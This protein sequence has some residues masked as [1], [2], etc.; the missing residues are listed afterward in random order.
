MC[1]V[2]ALSLYDVVLVCSARERSSDIEC[3]FNCVEL[4]SERVQLKCDEELRQKCL[5]YMVCVLYETATTT[6]ARRDCAQSLIPSTLPVDIVGVVVVAAVV[7]ATVFVVVV[8]VAVSMSVMTAAVV[9][10]RR[11]H[12]SVRRNEINEKNQS[13]RRDTCRNSD[14][15]LLIRTVVNRMNVQ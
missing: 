9:A 1:D 7:V 11:S 8:T 15:V 12:A 5:R 13:P 4:F 10:M 14:Y 2:N 3:G 6:R